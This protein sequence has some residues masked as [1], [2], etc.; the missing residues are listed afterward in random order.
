MNTHRQRVLKLNAAEAASAAF[1]GLDFWEGWRHP[2]S[3]LPSHQ[4]GE[5]RIKNREELCFR[6][7]KEFVATLNA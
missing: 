5:K 7:L 4:S 2:L 1:K 3:L 6:E